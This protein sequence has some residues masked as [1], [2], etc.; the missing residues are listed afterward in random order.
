VR[1][2]VNGKPCDLPEGITLPSLILHLGLKSPVFAVE[3]NGRPVS[4]SQ[5]ATTT[6]KSNDR[7]EI[8][9]FVGGG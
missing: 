1:V 4:K 2:L 7:I 6:L 3:I 9:E 8:V 5:H